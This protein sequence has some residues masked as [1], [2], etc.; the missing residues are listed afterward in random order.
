M[1]QYALHLHDGK[2]HR[3]LFTCDYCEFK[4][5]WRRSLAIHIRTHTGDYI[6]VCDECGRKFASPSGLRSHNLRG[7]AHL[8]KMPP[9]NIIKCS[10]CFTI[11]SDQVLLDEHVSKTHGE[12]S[13]SMKDVLS[14]FIKRDDIVGGVIQCLLCKVDFTD[15]QDYED[16]LNSHNIANQ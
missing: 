13:P 14:P 10:L 11:F 1:S 15:E 4:T 5:K 8:K 9:K 6:H 12:D 16:H 3:Q 7:H 2:H